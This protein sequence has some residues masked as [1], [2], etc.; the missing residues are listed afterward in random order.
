MDPVTP[1]E[2]M[3]GLRK[4]NSALDDIICIDDDHVKLA[5]LVKLAES[6]DPH[7]IYHFTDT[8]YNYEV[9]SR[10]QSRLLQLLLNHPAQFRCW[11][12]Y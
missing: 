8:A 11:M 9:L 6:K 1:I 4:L 12:Q 7:W 5:E 10:A 2:A 3:N